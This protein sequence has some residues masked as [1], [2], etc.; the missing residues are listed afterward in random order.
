MRSHRSSNSG[1]GGLWL[2]R[3]ALQPISCSICKL[4]FQ[5]AG[6]DG[7]AERAEIVVVANAVDLHALAV[8]QKAIVR[9]ELNRA[10]AEW[11]FV[12]VH[13]FAVLLQ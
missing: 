7:R 6:V 8:E 5:R 4:A 10:D 1:A 9:G 3:M 12:P 13:D 11:R 2:V